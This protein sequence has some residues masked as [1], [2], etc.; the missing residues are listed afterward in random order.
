[1]RSIALLAVWLLIPA[2]AAWAE[3]QEPVPEPITLAEVLAAGRA[4]SPQI[5]A[6]R[7]REQAAAA[8]AGV[9]GR[10]SNPA[11]EFRSENWGADVPGG[12]RLDSFAT[13][14]QR[15]E[16][17]GKRRA[18]RGAARAAAE[19]ARA[20]AFATAQAI[21]GE[22]A[23]RFLEAV[24][25]RDRAGI[26]EGQSDALDELVRILER[27]VIEGLA[28]DAERARLA[29]ERAAVAIA[30]TRAETAADRALLEL[31]ALAALP[32]NA[33][34]A[35]LV[36]P[37]PV[38]VPTGDP[39]AL[40][41]DAA[42]ARPDVRAAAARVETAERALRLENSL[43][44]PDLT[45]NTGLKRTLDTNTGVL[46]VGVG[47]P[48]FDR[49]QVAT[50]VARGEVRAAELERDFVTR[51]AEADAAAALLNALRLAEAAADTAAQLVE[52]TTIAR[53]AMRS[54][55]DL[56]AADVLLVVDVERAFA[57]ARLL[58]NDIQIEAVA[59]AIAARLALGEAP[60][61]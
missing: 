47:L 7:S 30:L 31:R 43:R 16:L 54:A 3:Q 59:A 51:R 24:R 13:V 4:A 25:L 46:A 40:A 55:F 49:N 50:M 58:E 52:P 5:A 44:I 11:I 42:A 33:T 15:L 27:R 14:T 35:A 53:T 19:A 12:L 6:A 29:A 61:P 17:G 56:G 36:R 23:G 18:R 39:A 21:E 22:M 41:A 28:P 57:N 2:P 45:V 37:D 8:A 38:P 1:M 32:D 20:D 48:L 10:W 9:A 26:L 60:L 34:A